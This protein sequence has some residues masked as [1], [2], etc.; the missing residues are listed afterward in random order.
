MATGYQRNL[1]RDTSEDEDGSGPEAD[2]SA[3][4]E[5][6]D[7]PSV[8]YIYILIQQHEHLS[9]HFLPRFSRALQSVDGQPE[10][11]A[12][13]IESFKN[14]TIEEPAAIDPAAID[15]AAIDPAAIEVDDPFRELQPVYIKRG[16]KTAGIYWYLLQ[17]LRPAINLGEIKAYFTAE[18]ATSLSDKNS[19]AFRNVLTYCRSIIERRNVAKWVVGYTNAARDN[20][21]SSGMEQRMRNKYRK[22]CW[23][24]QPDTSVAMI[25]LGMFR[26]KDEATRMEEYI[27]DELEKIPCVNSIKEPHHDGKGGTAQNPPYRY[28][29]YI[30]LLKQN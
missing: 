25:G 9:K 29:T 6:T 11:E 10:P 8:E 26:T 22:T 2:E 3:T 21:L 28:I 1:D 5:L 18:L 17:N 24:G 23:P 19:E 12:D 13:I 20:D 15:P 7:V 16:S 4:E 14:M 27:R 30:V